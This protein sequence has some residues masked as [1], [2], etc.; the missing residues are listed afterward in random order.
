MRHLKVLASSLAVV[1]LLVMA[2]DYVAIAATGKPV[3]L[4]KLNTAGK[5]TI[6]K[7]G[8]GP[9]LKLVT[10]PGK[11][12]LA[13]KRSVLVKKLNA[14][15]VDGKSASQ[16]GV[17]AQVHTFE[18]DSG[19]TTFVERTFT[20]VPAGTYIASFDV[21]L[22]LDDNV[23]G[24]CYFNPGPGS[25]GNASF[26]PHPLGFAPISA[27]TL[28]KLDETTDVDL[29]CSF[30]ASTPVSTYQTGRAWFTPVD[31]ASGATDFRPAVNAKPAGR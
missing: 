10:K 5:T 8:S 4:G 31:V 9:A 22:Y 13:V 26:A 14:D 27:T 24:F 19:S 7:S 21:W 11:P 25:Q 28:M 1:A 17:R 23:G 3:I 18:M 30:T 12:P 2:T 15:K 20:D 29:S 6:I 16:L